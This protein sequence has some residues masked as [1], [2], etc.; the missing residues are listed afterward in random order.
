MAYNDLRFTTSASADRVFTVDRGM[1]LFN[2]LV[3]GELLNLEL[4]NLAWRNYTSVDGVVQ[5]IFRYLE[6]LTRESV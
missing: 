1:P 5:S 6:P 4:Q 2:T 3:W